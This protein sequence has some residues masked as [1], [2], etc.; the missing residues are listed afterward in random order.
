MI[1][2][3]FERLQTLHDEAPELVLLVAAALE[4]VDVFNDELDPLLAFEGVDGPMLVAHCQPAQSHRQDLGLVR[5]ESHVLRQDVF[6]EVDDELADLGADE[7]PLRL[8]LVVEAIC[9]S[10][11]VHDG[12]G[13]T[14]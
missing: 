9:V 4:P 12:R 6:D 11:D 2:D 8:H 10:C 14:L 1:Q 7:F 5:F 13:V 3:L